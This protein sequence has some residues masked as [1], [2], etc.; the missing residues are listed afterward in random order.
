MDALDSRRPISVKL[1]SYIEKR[2]ILWLINVGI[3]NIN[4]F[5]QHHIGFSFL[6]SIC[7]FFMLSLVEVPSAGHVMRKE[8]LII[9]GKGTL[10]LL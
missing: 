5:N 10:F 8:T 1:S 7:H 6:F 9:L 3:E 2:V 4:L